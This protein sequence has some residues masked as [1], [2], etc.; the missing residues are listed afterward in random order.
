MACVV[1]TVEIKI[2]SKTQRKF[3]ILSISDA[4]GDALEIP[5]W[6]DLYDAQQE[7]L[8]E[9][10]LLW[11]VFTKEFR[12]QETSISCRFLA[13]VKNITQ[14]I[15]EQSYAAYEKAK[16][17]LSTS[18]YASSKKP[19]NI[20]EKDS[21]TEPPVTTFCVDLTSFRA[22]HAIT[23]SSLLSSTQGKD[24][25]QIAFMKRKQVI[26]T[27]QLPP[28]SLS[29]SISKAIEQL[30]CWLATQEEEK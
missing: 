17:Q 7:I 12:N 1:E 20:T 13:E 23:V 4:A 8:K 30:P 15:I 14:A 24:R 6:S 3:A 19:K 16:S 11:G 9:N 10:N 27:L 26:S 21:K 25:L 2:S 18:R 29:S 22:S 5:I 28:T